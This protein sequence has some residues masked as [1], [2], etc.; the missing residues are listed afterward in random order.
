[1]SYILEALRRAET[2][3]ERKRRV[4]G[5]HAQPVASALPEERAM[6]RNKAWLWVALGV[7]AGVLLPVLWRWWSLDPVSEEP[8]VSA[9][10]PVAGSVT[11]PAAL[12]QPPT[13]A[14][15]PAPT[16]ASAP[17]VAEAAAPT[18]V[19]RERPSQPRSAPAK[20]T[21]KTNTAREP[22]PAVAAAAPTATPTAAAKPAAAASAPEPKLRSLNEMPDDVRRAVPQL[23][24]GGSVYSE[25]AA[26]RMVIF[27]GQVLREGDPVTEEVQLEQI[28]PHSAV[29]RVRGQRFEIAF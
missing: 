20:A 7:G 9:R 8:V 2:E 1:M 10:A 24:F 4:P 12:E 28:R 18:A 19:A 16:V 22:A 14:P 11:P 15:A 21:P 17:A 26:Q 25:L 27:N 3:R 13:P 29:M 5:L 6:R 23:S